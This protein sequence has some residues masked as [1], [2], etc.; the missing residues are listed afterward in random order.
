[1]GIVIFA[2]ITFLEALAV[3]LDW[4]ISSSVS[5]F[6][7]VPDCEVECRTFNS[8]ELSELDSSKFEMPNFERPPWITTIFLRLSGLTLYESP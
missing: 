7:Y 8:G 5:P 2:F 4:V 1:M 3:F 6:N